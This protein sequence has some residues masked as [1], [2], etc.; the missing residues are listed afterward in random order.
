MLP[1]API[2]ADDGN[3][4]AVK[5]ILDRFYIS[6]QNAV[7]SCANLPE[8]IDSVKLMAGISTGAG[9]V[10]A[11]GGTAGA[12]AGVMKKQTRAD[13]IAEV[14]KEVKPLNGL[15][16]LTDDEYVA[17]MEKNQDLIKETFSE[18]EIE[19]LEAAIIKENNHGEL[20][21]DEE[22]LIVKWWAFLFKV[23]DETLI[24]EH[25]GLK[26]AM[27]FALDNRGQIEP[28]VNKKAA[29]RSIEEIEKLKEFDRQLVSKIKSERLNDL[30]K[31]FNVQSRVRAAGS[32]AAGAFG[33]AGALTAKSG[34]DKLDDAIGHMDKC[35]SHVKEIDVQKMKLSF[36]DPGNPIL[37]EMDNIVKSCGGMNPKVFEDIKGKLKA[38]GIMQ[39]VGGAAG[40]AGGVTS[41]AIKQKYDDNA[42]TAATVLSGAA[43]VGTGI[44]AIIGAAALAGLIKNGDIAKTCADAFN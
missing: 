2:L 12:V 28:I 39:A 36:A 20:S 4:A 44:G 16:G 37:A 21:E 8:K 25:P 26:D 31:T 42:D 33:A 5:E 40:V 27:K 32:F 30:Q 24:K 15:Y 11:I 23:K 43:A 1:T 38:A 34:Y 35:G 6:R 22:E 41:L 3:Q 19:K 29:D 7:A 10:G 9:A 13:M 17:I 14:E 18:S